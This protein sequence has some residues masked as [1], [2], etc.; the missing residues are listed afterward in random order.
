[1]SCDYGECVSCDIHHVIMAECVSCDL[2]VEQMP[3][4]WLMRGL[5]ML[6]SPS[7]PEGKSLLV[8]R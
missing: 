4:V 3:P 1:M 6:A 8:N 7:K 5:A 2:L